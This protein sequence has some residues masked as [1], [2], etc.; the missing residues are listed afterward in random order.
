MPAESAPLKFVLTVEAG[1]NQATSRQARMANAEKLQA[2]G[3]VDD[4]YV[5]H[6]HGIK[7]AKKI[8]ER[9]YMKRQKG[10]IGG[11]AAQRKASGRQK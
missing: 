7:D 9:L 11:G 5:L 4:E 1:A 6:V 3:I 10:L 2:L 8:L